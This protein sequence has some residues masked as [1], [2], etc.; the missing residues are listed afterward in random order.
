MMADALRRSLGQLAFSWE[1]AAIWSPPT[2]RG[3]GTQ[4]LCEPQTK[5]TI[6][7]YLRS[8]GVEPTERHRKDGLVSVAKLELGE[9][10]DVPRETRL[11]RQREAADLVE[12]LL[13]MIDRGVG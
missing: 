12:R 6:A 4:P 2:M 11:L 8:F 5:V 9:G 3:P 7:C 10:D 1:T 13:S